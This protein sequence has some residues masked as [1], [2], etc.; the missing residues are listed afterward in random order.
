MTGTT[1]HQSAACEFPWY[2]ELWRKASPRRSCGC[3]FFMYA[4]IRSGPLMTWIGRL[5]AIASSSSPDVRTQQEKSRA[6]LRIAER[7]VRSSVFIIARAT[8]SK[9]LL[10]SAS[11]SGD[12]FGC[13]A[14]RGLA[15][16]ECAG[17]GRAGDERVD[18]Q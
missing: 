9:R 2:G 8:P 10:S 4:A 13:S 3:V 7:A 17:A 14:T 5:S 11:S 16:D 18:Q 15:L 6:V 1:T 12:V